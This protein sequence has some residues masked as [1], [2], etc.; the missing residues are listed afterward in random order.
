MLERIYDECP[1]HDVK[2]II[3]DANAQVGR[4]EFFR[5]VI[6]RHGLHSSTNEN[7][8]RLINFA[9]ARGMAICSSYFPRLN[10]QKHTWRHLNGEACSQIDQVLIDGR[11]FSDSY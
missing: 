9:A 10:T 2:V 11:Q 8:L 1:K 4:E 7:G 6:G 3:G 5:P